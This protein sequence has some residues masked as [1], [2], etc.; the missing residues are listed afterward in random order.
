MKKTI[1]IVIIALVVLG[2]GYFLFKISPNTPVSSS[3]AGYNASLD[4]SGAKQLSAVPAF[5]PAVDRYLGNAKAK[6]VFIEYADFQCPACAA[7]SPELKQVPDKFPDTVFVYRYFP[8]T[9]I[10]P[11]SVESAVAVEAAGAQGKYWEMHD[12]L[13][14]NQS[15]WEGLTDP[16]DAFAQYAQTAG[17]SDINQFKADVTSKKYLAAVENGNNQALGLNLSGTPSYFFNGH[18]LQSSD[19]AGLLSQAQQFVNK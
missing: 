5:D 14:A 12:L 7:A 15:N 2:F 11:N 9:Q 8:L 1:T 18:E 13:F 16:L 10:H 3:V 17:V 4:V 19:L 6:N